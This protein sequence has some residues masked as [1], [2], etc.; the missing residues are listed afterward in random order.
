[1]PIKYADNMLDLIN[2]TR[3][4]EKFIL[5]VH[6]FSDYDD[7]ID[8]NL[9]DWNVISVTPTRIRIKLEFKE[10]LDVSS[11]LKRDKLTV[12]INLKN[13]RNKQEIVLPQTILIS[14][15]PGQMAS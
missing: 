12:N 8:E 3:G 9:I 7:W 14:E 1:M 5:D 6:L 11:G 15:V 13:H 10:P 4:S 2:E